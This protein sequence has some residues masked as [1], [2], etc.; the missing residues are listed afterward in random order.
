[1]SPIRTRI[2]SPGTSSRAGGVTH[3]PSR[4][5]RH[6]TASWAFSAS[7]AFPAWC[8]SQNPTV[9]LATSSSKMMKKSGQWRSTPDKITAASIIHGIG[10]QKYVSSFSSGLAFLSAISFGPYLASRFPA[11]AWVRPSGDDDSRFSTSGTGR[12]FRSSFASGSGTAFAPGRPAPV[13]LTVLMLFSRPSWHP[14]T[15]CPSRGVTPGHPAAP[16]HIQGACQES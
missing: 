14:S 5:T 13:S 10:P 16:A 11:S 12:D 2:T 9:A 3:V 6:L 8:S 4:I 7:M 15:R 1:M